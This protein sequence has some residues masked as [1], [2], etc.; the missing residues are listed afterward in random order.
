MWRR[1][2]GTVLF[3]LV[4]LCDAIVGAKEDFLVCMLAYCGSLVERPALVGT[5]E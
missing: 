2:W 4:H 3:S 1:Y 5:R